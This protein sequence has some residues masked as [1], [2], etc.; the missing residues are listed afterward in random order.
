[1]VDD[2]LYDT[3]AAPYSVAMAMQSPDVLQDTP[4]PWPVRVTWNTSPKKSQVRDGQAVDR[5]W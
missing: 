4:S 5:I 1:M 2:L 3:G